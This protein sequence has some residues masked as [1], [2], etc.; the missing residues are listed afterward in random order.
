MD[1][2]GANGMLVLE[3]ISDANPKA[4]KRIRALGLREEPMLDRI[5]PIPS[6][7]VSR[8]FLVPKP[9]TNKWQLVIDYR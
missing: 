1:K 4:D 5:V 8:R 3:P 7:S 2:W 9:V 6:H